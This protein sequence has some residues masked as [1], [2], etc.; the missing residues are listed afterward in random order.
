MTIENESD[1]SA[2]RDFIIESQ[3]GVS[4]S[5]DIQGCA[6]VEVNIEILTLPLPTVFYLDFLFRRDRHIVY[7]AVIMNFGSANVTSGEA[8]PLGLHAR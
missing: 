5:G 6:N 2:M 3:Y 1:T 8:S 4:V 7:G